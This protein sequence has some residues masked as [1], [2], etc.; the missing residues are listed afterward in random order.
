[1]PRPNLNVLLPQPQFPINRPDEIILVPN[2]FRDPY[3]SSD[4]SDRYESDEYFGDED[5]EDSK[6]EKVKQE[7]RQLKLRLFLSQEL[8]N[9]MMWSFNMKS[10]KLVKRL[11]TWRG[12]WAGQSFN[13]NPL[14]VKPLTDNNLWSMM[15]DLED[16]LEEHIDVLL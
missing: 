3:L 7:I 1:M 2:N 4:D 14:Y 11:K 15:G 13:P 10:L 5:S 12:E 16:D 9:M 8:I 6:Q